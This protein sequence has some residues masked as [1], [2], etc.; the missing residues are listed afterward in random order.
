MATGLT[1]MS[2]IDIR[3]HPLYS[4]PEWEAFISSDAGQVAQSLSGDE[5]V[6]VVAFVL[7]WMYLALACCG[8]SA[9]SV[10]RRLRGSKPAPLLS[11][12]AIAAHQ[13]A[14]GETLPPGSLHGLT[15][16]QAEAARRAAAAQ[17]AVVDAAAGASSEE[18]A[19]V[20]LKWARNGGHSV[21][22]LLSVS[23]LIDAQYLI[24]LAEFGGIIPPHIEVPASAFLR[25]NA[26]SA[27]PRQDQTDA[28]RLRCWPGNSSVSVVAVSCPSLDDDHP[29]NRG[30]M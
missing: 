12:E 29:D 7:P 5:W 4:V 14:G 8:E 9:A 10:C 2:S 15:S 3:Q 17:Q 25:V 1:A 27:S 26:P 16:L 19:R 20:D 13:R 24:A 28:W 23:P 18:K 22:Q 6:M 11:A 21:E 30:Q